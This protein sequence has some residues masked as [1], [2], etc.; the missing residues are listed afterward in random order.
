MTVAPI[1]VSRATR[2]DADRVGRALADAFVDDPVFAWLIPLDARHR[3]RRLRMYF[4]SM[5]RSYLRRDK[6]VYVAGDD[7][8][9]ALWSAPGHWELPAIEIVR[10]SR[11]AASAFGRNL[12]RALRCQL[13]IESLHPKDRQH[14]YLGY[15]GTRGPEQGKGIGSA[16]LRQ[17]LQ[18][19]DRDRLPSY[20]ES[21]CER[22]LALYERHGF[23][24]V[25]QVPLLGS[26]PTVWRMWREPQD[27]AGPE[28]S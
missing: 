21:S 12:V 22:N 19:A 11:S 5:S 2:A 8:A 4:T 17:V 1:T 18:V 27:P 13:Q 28:L 20:L 6:H 16:L 10:E 3:D 25:E 15:L 7:Q 26:G 9:G 14:W 24:I 23:R